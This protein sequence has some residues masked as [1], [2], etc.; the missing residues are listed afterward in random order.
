MPRP[1]TAGPMLRLSSPRI[2]TAAT[3]TMNARIDGRPQRVE[4][5]HPLLDLDRGQ[6][7]RGALGRLAV[8]RRLDEAV[9]EAPGEHDEDQRDDDDQQDRQDNVAGG[10]EQQVC[11][12]DGMSMRERSVAGA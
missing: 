3:T 5:V 7:L 2:I 10:V 11:T 1:A 9:D 6:L 8:E 12:A 4:R